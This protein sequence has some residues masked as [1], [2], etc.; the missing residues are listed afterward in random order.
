MGRG[1]HPRGS[2]SATLSGDTI[3]VIIIVKHAQLIDVFLQ[4]EELL[5]SMLILRKMQA[6]DL[7]SWIYTVNKALC[8]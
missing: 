6:I 8:S 1:Q 4:N 5:C 2:L 3:D 7:F